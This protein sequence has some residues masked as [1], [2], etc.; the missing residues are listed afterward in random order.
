MSYNRISS[1]G[2]TKQISI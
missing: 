2:T 1:T